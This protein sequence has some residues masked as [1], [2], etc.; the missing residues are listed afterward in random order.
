MLREPQRFSVPDIFKALDAYERAEDEFDTQRERIEVL[1]V[2]S[3][4]IDTVK[5]T[6]G[7]FFKDGADDFSAMVAG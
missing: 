2:G 7:Q 4:S 3:D 6:H 5:K 1:L